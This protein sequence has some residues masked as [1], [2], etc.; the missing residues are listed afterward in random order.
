[1]NALR[2]IGSIFAFVGLVFLLVGFG[3]SLHTLRFQNRAVSSTGKIIDFKE[4]WVRG[5]RSSISHRAYSPVVRFQTREGKEITF[6]GSTGFG[7]GFKLEDKV[8]VLYD[9]QDP[10]H[11]EIDTFGSRWVVPALSTGI[12]TISFLLG[13]SMIWFPWRSRKKI[14]WFRQ[15]G[16]KISGQFKRVEINTRVTIN[17]KHPH[18]VVCDAADPFSGQ[19]REFRSKNLYY[20]PTERLKETTLDIWEDHDHPKRYGVDIEFLREETD[21]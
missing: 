12:G 20:D 17:D 16:L 15:H 6:E 18:K 1:M 21:S 19:M 5:E 4:H 9:P 14:D 13:F 10:S 7:S 3:M 11:A 2:F 8:R